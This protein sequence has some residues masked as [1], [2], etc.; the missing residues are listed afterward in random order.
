M[1]FLPGFTLYY[2][3]PT[4]GFSLSSFALWTHEFSFFFPSMFPNAILIFLMLKLSQNWPPRPFKLAS[5][6]H[7]LSTSLI[8]GPSQMFQVHLDCT[9][10]RTSHFSTNPGSFCG[11]WYLGTVI[12]CRHERP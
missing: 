7:S 10:A 4:F 11:G 1:P 8:L 12:W 2:H 6:H 9:G 3:F 5:L